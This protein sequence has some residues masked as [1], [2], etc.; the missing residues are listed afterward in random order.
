MRPFLLTLLLSI[1][2]ATE[3]WPAPRIAAFTNYAS[4]ESMQVSPGGRYL[5]LTRR[6]EKQEVLTVLS[7][8]DMKGVAQTHFGEQTDIATLMWVNDKRLLVTPARRAVGETAYK[9]RTGEI[10]GIDFDGKNADVLVGYN[11]GGKATR[12]AAF[13]GRPLEAPAA[14]VGRMPG[15][16]DEVL[17]RMGYWDDSK[18]MTALYRL[19]AITGEAQPVGIVSARAATFVTDEAGRP[20]L[21]ASFDDAANVPVLYQAPKA[22]DWKTLSSTPDVDGYLWPISRWTTKGE[23]LALDSRGAPTRGVV[24]LTAETGAVRPLFS[25]PVADMYSLGTYPNGP[26]WG[27]EYFDHFPKYWY[28][29]PEHPLAKA[30]QWLRE[31]LRGQRVNITSHSTDM[32][33]LTAHVSSPK[34][35]PA[36]LLVDAKNRAVI[37]R[38]FTHP[39]LKSEDLSAVEP[40]EVTARDGLEIRGY[41]TLPNTTEKKKLPTVVLVHDGPEERDIYEFDATPQLIASRGYVVLQVNYR[42]STGLGRAFETAGYGQWGKKIQDDVTD[43]VQWA[44]SDGITDPK[45]ICISGTGF[46][47][48]IALTATYR[49]PELFRCAVGFSGHYDLPLFNDVSPASEER[50]K[51]W[52]EVHLATQDVE[53]LKRRSPVY[54]AEKIRARVMLIHGQQDAYAPLEHA[55]K[56]RAALEKAGNPPEWMTRPTDLGSFYGEGNRET[57]SLEMMRFFAKHLKEPVP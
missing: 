45:R 47:A 12:R 7:L 33:L 25:S 11:G 13:K 52:L 3:A 32:S 50:W 39:G 17:V 21:A 57:S 53:E 35:P 56:M 40:F 44:I 29:D 22:A 10:I 37:Q 19:N 6:T 18:S 24:V 16:A 54:N 30:H 31:T 28:P 34:S 36:F 5:A 1:C 9:F 23:Y 20:A 55:Q 46:G 48:Y 27:F 41:L 8:P 14:L 49:E 43:A 38:L 15:A 51:N 26:A 4:Y 2:V 42:G